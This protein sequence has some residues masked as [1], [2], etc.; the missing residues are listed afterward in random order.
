M[1]GFAEY[2]NYDGLGLAELV[3]KGAVHPR[4]LVEASI[5]RI[6]AANPRLNAVV[7]RLYDRALSQADPCLGAVRRSSLSAEGP[8]RLAP[9]GADE[10][11]QPPAQGDPPNL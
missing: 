8:R 4:E 10:P 9:F 7:T 5:A 1:G 2:G 6:E 11:G 3:A